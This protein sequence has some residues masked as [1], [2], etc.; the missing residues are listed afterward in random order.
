MATTRISSSM[1]TR[2]AGRTPSGIL[3][4]LQ[5]A[6]ESSPY[7]GAS[8]SQIDAPSYQPYQGCLGPFDGAPSDT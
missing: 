2:G 4:N 7:R 6:S 3:S 1:V 5:I 8:Q